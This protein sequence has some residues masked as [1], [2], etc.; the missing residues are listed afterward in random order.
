MP[1]R[2]TCVVFGKPGTNTLRVLEELVGAV[3]DTGALYVSGCVSHDNEHSR[4]A[5]E[6]G[7]RDSTET[8]LQGDHPTFDETRPISVCRSL[9]AQ[10]PTK[11]QDAHLVSGQSLGGKVLSTSV[12]TPLNET[13]VQ[14]HEVLHLPSALPEFTCLV[15]SHTAHSPASSR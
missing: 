10:R 3:L 13:R 8:A 14:T 1:R 5:L 9:G 7:S 15:L 12:E 11:V 4:H 2:L 6:R